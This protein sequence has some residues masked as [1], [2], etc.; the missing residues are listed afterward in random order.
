MKNF[1]LLLL[2]TVSF[3]ATAQ[4][5][6][7]HTD[8]SMLNKQKKPSTHNFEKYLIQN[9]KTYKIDTLLVK[10]GSFSI[11]NNTTT[12]TPFAVARMQPRQALIFFVEPKKDFSLTLFEPSFVIKSSK[13]SQSQNDYLAFMKK[14][15]AIQQESQAA[16]GTM[17]QVTNK[18]SLRNRVKYLQMQ[19]NAQ[20]IEFI[21]EQKD[22]NMGAY[23][24]FDVANKNQ[25][26]SANDLSNLFG[27]L[28]EKGKN[29]FYGKQVSQRVVKLTSMNVGSTAPDFTLKDSKGKKHTLKS[30]R[31]KYVLLDF[32]ASWCG[33]CVREIPH[34]KK[35]YKEYHDKG[36][37]IMSVSIDRKKGQWLKAVDKYKMP[38]VSVIDHEKVSDKIT[39]RLY[40]VPTIP[41]TVLLD[42]NGVV[43]GKDFRGAA[44]ENK[45]Q[46][47]FKK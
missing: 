21:N 5:I 38:W 41:R 22:N 35:A 28:S 44:L 40:H 15:G 8:M 17:A 43:V 46:E 7:I 45:L 2:L 25:R 33:P 29:T 10:N 9:L 34:L 4:N 16:Q 42:K 37:E 27:K 36:F 23:M 1:T 24:V 11:P 32:W 47:L 30:L 12:I 3:C 39:Q 14:Q 20:F 13:G 19:M 31:G 26:I 6:T 18:D